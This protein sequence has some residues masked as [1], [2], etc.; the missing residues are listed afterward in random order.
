M[1]VLAASPED[2]AA[3]YLLGSLVL[4]LD[5]LDR[6]VGNL[7]IAAIL[8]PSFFE[9]WLQLASLELTRGNLGSARRASRRTL[10]IAPLMGE[11][12]LM[13]ARIEEAAGAFGA[14]MIVLERGFPASPD[15]LP[16]LVQHAR[17]AIRSG[18]EGKAERGLKAALAL[19][20]A[21]NDVLF[22]IGEIH[23][24]R[25][26]AFEALLAY[27]RSLAVAPAFSR[28]LLC[29]A[30]LGWPNGRKQADRQV[31]TALAVEPQ[32]VDGW[33]H[34]GEVFRKQQ[35]WRIA[36]TVYQRVIAFDAGHVRSLTH[37]GNVLDEADDHERAAAILHRVCLL[38]P[39]SHEAHANYG[40]ALLHCDRFA[41]AAA[42]YRRAVAL[43]PDDAATHYNL[44]NANRQFLEIG[45]ALKDF[46]RA[47]AVDPSYALAHWNDGLTRLMSGDYATGWKK[48]D[49]R[50][51]DRLVQL[52]RYAP[53]WNGEPLQGRRIVL[54]GEQGYGDM[55]HF[56]RYASLLAGLGG[57]VVLEC[58]PEL[59][60]LFSSLDGDIELIDIGTAPPRI[61]FQAALMQVPMHLK[62]SVATIPAAIPYLRPPADG[63]RLPAHG[64]GLKVGLVW[65]GN[66]RIERFHKRSAKLA[67]FAPLLRIPGIALFSLQV[68]AARFE[69]QALGLSK[70]I[71]D[72]AP[73]IGDFADTASLIQ[74]LD[75][76]ISVDTSSAHVAGAIGKPVWTMINYVPDW[77]WLLGR[78]DT[79][80]YPTMRL[81]RQGPERSWPDVIARIAPDLAKMVG[82][83]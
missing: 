18:A 24:H 26:Q 28:A 63:P 29:A 3:R 71:V 22:L 35:S 79:P 20:P 52:P 8:Q 10:A 74:Q 27:E 49:G 54:F 45:S 78:S 80:W 69:I 82:D 67:D 65:S 51:H 73:L 36:A 33:F 4:H 12:L 60:R 70:D 1:Q 61:D 47:N 5:Q 25:E 59:R 9:S 7:R 14:A 2:P 21:H 15:A 62:T 6:A 68:G 40:T 72:L 56:A 37:L 50:W 75:L 43:R 38:D 57:S 48:Y 16:M 13:L 81:C 32:L 34:L 11:C 17:L 39:S 55:V 42:F 44:G 41:D 31:R 64:A 76:V 53:D 58:Y 66:P 19:A 30:V 83:A 46:G 77:R 23:R